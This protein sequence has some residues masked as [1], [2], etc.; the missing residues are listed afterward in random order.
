ALGC[1]WGARVRIIA[2]M[3]DQ[4]LPSSMGYEWTAMSFQEKRVGSQAIYVFGLAVLLVYMVLS[5]QYESRILPVAVILV[6]PLALFGTVAALAIR[7]M[8]NNI[9]TQI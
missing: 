8:D 6:V 4:K 7:G 3:A 9:Y 1:T 2:Q 5:G